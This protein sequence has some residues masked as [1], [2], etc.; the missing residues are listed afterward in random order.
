MFK[1]STNWIPRHENKYNEQI[2]FHVFINPDFTRV[3]TLIDCKIKDS[4]TQVMFINF[5]VGYVQQSA[6]E[7]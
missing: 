2:Y 6:I 4:T 3:F 5:T 7:N 1:L